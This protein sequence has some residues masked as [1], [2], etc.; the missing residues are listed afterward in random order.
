[1]KQPKHLPRLTQAGIASNASKHGLEH[2]THT[3][4]SSMGLSKSMHLTKV[5]TDF[6]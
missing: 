3:S 6:D 5:F 2:L 1:M 4:Y